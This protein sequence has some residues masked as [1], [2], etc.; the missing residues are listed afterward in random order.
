MV[1]AGGAGRKKVSRGALV[2]VLSLL[3]VAGVAHALGADGR[4]LGQAVGF[5]AHP[6]PIWILLALL[7]EVASFLVYA[8][9][10]RRLVM[11]TGRRLST[12]WLASLAVCAQAL[13]NFLPAGYV[14]GNTLSFR[15]LRHRGLAGGE[16]VW[17][18]VMSSV[19][20]IGSL[21]ALALIGT[22]IVGGKEGG[23]TRY[24]GIGACLLVLAVLGLLWLGM[25]RGAAART[26]P[27]IPT[28][29]GPKLWLLVARGKMGLSALMASLARVK[30]SRRGVAG[31]LFLFA[32]CWLLD[33][34]CLIAS[35]QAVGAQ[36]P[37]HSL[38]AA[39][40][41]AQ[42][43]SFLPVTPGGL[44]LV[45]GSLT[46]TLAAG[47]FAAVHVLSGVLLYRAISYWGALPAGAAG[48]A[49]IRRARAGRK[50]EARVVSPEWPVPT[51]SAS[52]SS[53]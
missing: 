27:A 42:L 7:S 4:E 26:Q 9:A 52:P 29:P 34:A 6:L 8:V 33:G 3:L 47:G 51:V 49:A 12:G 30:L 17:L 5:L 35:F 48:Y 16:S 11:A 45:E 46:V 23:A 39:Y 31:A 40:C 36:L 20:Y 43:V 41:G 22:V 25:R 10:Q 24:L 38:L 21:G 18:L 2:A 50:D 37:W 44:G 53:T 19:L 13:N 14:A 1:K 15:E 28:E 32:T